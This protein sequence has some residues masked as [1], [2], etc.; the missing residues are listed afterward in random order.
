[1][2][3]VAGCITVTL[4]AIMGL[5]C[6]AMAV[7]P[8][9]VQLGAAQAGYESMSTSVE[10]LSSFVV[11]TGLP[12]SVFS[13]YYPYP[14]NQEP[15]PAVYDPIK[16]ITYP[17][18]LTNPETVPESDP[19]P[20]YYPKPIAKLSVAEQKQIISNVTRQVRGVLASPD[21]SSNCSKCIAALSVAKSAAQLAPKLVPQAMVSLCNDTGTS[22]SSCE[23][24]YGARKGIGT[25]WTQV[26][27]LADVSGLDGQYICNRLSSSYCPAPETLPLNTTGLFPKPKPESWKVPKASGKRV[28]VVQLSDIH[29]DSR[30]K[31]GSEVLLTASPSWILS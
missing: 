19:D 13:S 28:K 25:I 30:Y 22:L 27:A 8:L 24:D 26:L 5:L 18:N 1:M 29:I 21:Y 4:I 31:I 11:P 7:S 10:R 9:L 17:A 23:A 12:T 15:Q 20:L 16:N 2:G 3:R 6:I 14:S